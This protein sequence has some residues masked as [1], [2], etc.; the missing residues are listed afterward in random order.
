MESEEL[1]VWD[2]IAMHCHR[3]GW[4]SSANVSEF[5]AGVEKQAWGNPQRQAWKFKQPYYDRALDAT[6]YRAN[7][8][9]AMAR[10]RDIKWGCFV[11]GYDCK[12]CK[13]AERQ[14][15]CNQRG[16]ISHF[17]QYV[18]LED[19]Q[20]EIHEDLQKDLKEKLVRIWL[21]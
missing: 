14:G 17:W 8:L 2:W 11:S 9:V 1:S 18:L 13:L 7:F 15:Q 16:S 5:L 21:K 4:H 19:S 3:L 10:N 20:E 6:L 12:N